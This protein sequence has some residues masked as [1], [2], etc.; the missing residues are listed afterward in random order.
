MGVKA[1]ITIRCSAEK[2]QEISARLKEAL[3]ATGENVNVFIKTKVNT[4]DSD[5]I[6]GYNRF[7]RLNF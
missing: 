6:S 3:K 2:A 4:V 7:K 1:D 5:P